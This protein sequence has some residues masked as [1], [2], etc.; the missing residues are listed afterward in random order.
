MN[1]I[2]EDQ[3]GEDYWQPSNMMEAGADE[4]PA[5]TE[6]GDEQNVPELP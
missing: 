1:P 4:E 3:G 5:P 6:A 2:S